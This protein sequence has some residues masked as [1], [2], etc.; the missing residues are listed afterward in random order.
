MKSNKEI[1]VIM[2]AG[3]GSRMLPLTET[4][5]K[6]LIPVFATPMIETLISALLK[7][8]VEK[9]YIVTGYKSEQF[10]YLSAKY[11][12][13]TLVKN[14]EYNT[15]N[16]ISSLNLVCDYLGAANCFIC[17]A[18]LLV[19]D[20]TIFFF[21]FQQSCYFGKFVSGYSSD[22]VFEMEAERITKITKGGTDLFNMTGVSYWLKEDAKQIA[23]AVRAASLVADNDQR[24]WDEIVNLL[25][26]K[27]DLTIYP[28]TAK[29]LVEI[30]TV[31]ELQEVRR[32]LA[33]ADYIA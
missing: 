30:D 17:E 15:K 2:A 20:E 27:I 24:F 16:N 6:P 25:L 29:Q 3:L 21:D 14:E 1:A 7:R 22:W 10:D 26:D 19:N 12:N 5:A 23:Q 18:D 13:I 33:A 11:S 8:E 4:L 28:V 31:A 9:L 32:T